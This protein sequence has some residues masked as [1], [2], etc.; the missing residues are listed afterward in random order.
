MTS[1][2][3]QPHVMMPSLDLLQSELGALAR[4]QNPSMYDSCRGEGL[5]LGH[6]AEDRE[7]TVELL[8]LDNYEVNDFYR[9][10]PH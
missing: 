10:I 7:N 6:R 9:P 5:V 1:K 4:Q 3:P 8:A 2:A